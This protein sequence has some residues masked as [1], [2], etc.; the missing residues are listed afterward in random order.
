MHLLPRRA[1]DKDSEL[2][3]FVSEMNELIEK[4]ILSN[5]IDFQL[6]LKMSRENAITVSMTFLTLQENILN[7]FNRSAWFKII[8]T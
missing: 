8:T 3:E 6:W 2:A 4:G 5:P 7:I 1:L